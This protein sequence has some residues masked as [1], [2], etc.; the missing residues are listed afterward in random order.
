MKKNFEG[1]VLF[2]FVFLGIFVILLK[3]DLSSDSIFRRLKIP[4][5]STQTNMSVREERFPLD[6]NKGAWR[7]NPTQD[8]HW[9]TLP[10][11]CQGMLEKI[12]DFAQ[13]H[14]G[15]YTHIVVIGMGG[16]SRP[17]DVI[18][19]V[20]GTEEGWAEIH[21]M[22]N[23]DEADI[24]KIKGEI[25]P[26]RTLFISIS[27]SGTTAETNALT[28][29]A[30]D[31]IIQAGLDPSKHFIAITTT[32]RDSF[33][34]KFLKD[35]NVPLENI[36]EHPDQ[37]GGRYTIFSVI[38]MLPAAL[39]GHDINTILSFA[40]QAM[41]SQVKYDLGEFLAK[42]ES[43]GRIYMRVVLPEELASL[44][45]WIE[46]LVAESLGKIDV[47]G[48]NRGIVPVLE[49]DYDEGIYN[50]GT[51][52]LRIKLGSSD[53]RDGFTERVKAKGVPVW[54]IQVNSPE[55]AIGGLYLLEFATGMAGV[56]MGI[57]P[58]D[59][60]GVE[61][62]KKATNRMKEEILAQ[63]NQGKT[64]EEAYGDFLESQRSI[65]R[66]EIA[67]GVTLDFGALM[68]VARDE[69]FEFIWEK[70]KDLDNLTAQEIYALVLEFAKSK[71][72]TYGAILPY[73]QET[74]ERAVTWSQARGVL[75]RFGL[76][77]I[78]GIG[79]VY[80][81]SLRQ[82]L[83]QGPDKGIPTFIVVNDIGTQVI[84]GEK[85]PGFTTGMQNVLQA[86]G[87]QQALTNAGRYT[88]RIEIEGPLTLDKL[89]VLESFFSGI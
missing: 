64:L 76:Q 62:G 46:Q 29:I 60:P 75:R 5:Q 9:L 56:L 21:V 85:I 7:E 81:H 35:N 82:Y 8:T 70:K 73:A 66:V 2:S 15:E 3:M 24:Q 44:G 67:P 69:F 40:R 11:D 84:P 38:G 52:C 45:P 50:E 19:G 71:G 31:W 55:E 57:D 28:R 49:R 61:E 10:L 68:Q 18:R 22:E 59:Q 79:P 27:K 14:K 54:E 87:T 74:T 80:E 16:S 88:I 30:Y 83:Q 25:D 48:R 58:F 43:E 26:T 89:R 53:A 72:K 86:L 13:R 77:D 20:L 23:L 6:P 4:F 41:E 78:Y 65:Y 32:S 33:L 42:M 17:A 37:V 36:F 47:V 12:V 39:A 63:I 1:I 51:F 34:M